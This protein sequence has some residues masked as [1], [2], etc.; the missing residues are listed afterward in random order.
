MV[1]NTYVF[2]GDV[3]IYTIGHQIMLDHY[4]AINNSS[5]LYM[6]IQHMHEDCKLVQDEVIVDL[7]LR[8]SRCDDIPYTNYTG[9]QQKQVQL[10]PEL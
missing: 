9:S 4:G 1:F 5:H 10:Y 8:F 2:S 7:F 3:C 6:I